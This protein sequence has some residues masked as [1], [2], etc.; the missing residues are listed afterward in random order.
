M[1]GESGR[2]E[3]LIFRVKAPLS[4]YELKEYV[5]SLLH[6][7]PAGIFWTIPLD[8]ARIKGSYRIIDTYETRRELVALVAVD[9]L[10]EL[11]WRSRS[12][13]TR[14]VWRRSGGR[15]VLEGELSER[16]LAKLIMI[17]GVNR[18]QARLVRSEQRPPKR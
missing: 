8:R 15:G 17:V 2:R 4:E 11:E 5:L 18:V 3:A 13:L 16:A 7:K 12:G 6:Q 1:S 14:F 10:E 9:R